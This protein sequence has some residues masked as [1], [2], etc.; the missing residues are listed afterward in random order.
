MH[1]YRNGEV[2]ELTDE[3]IKARRES[4]NAESILT[5]PTPEEQGITLLRAMAATATTL[6]DAVALSIPDLL[7]TWQELLA[8]GEP[9]QPGVCLTYNGQVYRMVQPT[10]VTPQAHQPP[11]GE[12]MLAVYRPIDR[13][14]TGTADDP[15]PWVSGMDCTAGTYYSYNGKVY[16]VA[17]GGS[18]APCTWP[19]DTPGM[20]QWEEIA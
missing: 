14:H 7:P 19:P 8:A 4:M 13:E 16:R 18:M 15:I 6:T 3:E 2:I 1:V 20:W 10:E 5:P 11:G 9:I 17:E 12:G